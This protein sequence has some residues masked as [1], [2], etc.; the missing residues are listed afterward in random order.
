MAST[1]SASSHPQTQAPGQ[2]PLYNGTIFHC[3]TDGFM[4]QGGDPQRD[5]RGGPVIPVGPTP[6]LTNRHTILG[7]V[8]Q[9]QEVVDATAKA[10][11]GRNDRPL[12][13]VTIQQ[14]PVKVGGL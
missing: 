11:T 14:F 10:P 6:H 1:R 12:T 9:G 5:G 13:D 2:G 3:V 4:I 7:E 8:V